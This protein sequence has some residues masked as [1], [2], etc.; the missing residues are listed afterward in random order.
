MKLS[1]IFL[2]V[3]LCAPGA[4]LANGGGYESGGEYG[5]VVPFEMQD[6]GL[7]AMDAEDLRIE[8]G[9]NVSHFHVRYTMRN[10]TSNRVKCRFGFPVEMLHDLQ[11]AGMGEELRQI[12]YE[13]KARGVVLPCKR[14]QDAARPAGMEKAVPLVNYGGR[15]RVDS[16]M[17]SE[18]TA[19]PGEVFDLEIRLK[20]PNR[21][22]SEHISETSRCSKWMHYRFSSA[23]VWNG[24]IR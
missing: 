20:A 1:G 23:R 9:P 10:T 5:S 13:A 7:I 24:S 6:I 12:E 18:L 4:C 21:I 19:E 11:D 8:V 15:E 17:V 2:G 3:A 22:S 16:W 14:V